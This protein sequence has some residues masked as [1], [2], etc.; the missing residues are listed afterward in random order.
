MPASPACR[1]RSGLAVAALAALL[2]LP[3]GA[4]QTTPEPPPAC[5]EAAAALR[6][7]ERQ[8][9]VNELP[10]VHIQARVA[11]LGCARRETFDDPVWFER[12]VTLFVQTFTAQGGDWPAT[13]AACAAAD[14]TQLLCVDRMVA[15]HIAGDLPPALRVTGCGTPG[16]WGRVGALIVE[17]AYR[18]GWIWGV[19]AEVGVPWQRDRVRAAC[20]RGEAAPAGPA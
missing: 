10:F 12:T 5:L 15:R 2:W 17:A 19:G 1:P 9:G 3:A 6:A 4:A 7:Y 18:E 14:M 13:V 20:L 11:E 16:D 8:A